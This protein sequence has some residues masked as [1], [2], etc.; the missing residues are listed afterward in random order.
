[1]PQMGPM[2]W[3]LSLIYSL[4]IIMMFFILI[5]YIS[6]PIKLKSSYSSSPLKL[7]NALYMKWK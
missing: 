3:T 5:H 7:N 6:S 4:M 1:M 2:M